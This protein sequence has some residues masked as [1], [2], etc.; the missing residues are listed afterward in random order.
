MRNK[1]DEIKKNYKIRKT[2]YLIMRLVA[3]R[4]ERIA[5]F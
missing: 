2:N 5:L 1:S 3:Q 4:V